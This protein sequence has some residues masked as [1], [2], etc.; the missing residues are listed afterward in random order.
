[1]KGLLTL[2]IVVIA[3]LVLMDP[4]GSPNFTTLLLV[5]GGVAV[6]LLVLLFATGSSVQL[7]G[8]GNTIDNST[9]NVTIHERQPSGAVRR[10]TEYKD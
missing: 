6:I 8:S 10:Y 3:G 5:I 1:M 2:V 4:F 7:G 9:K